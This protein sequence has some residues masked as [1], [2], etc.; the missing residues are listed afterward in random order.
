MVFSGGDRWNCI[1]VVIRR[2]SFRIELILFHPF[3]QNA[4]NGCFF[5]LSDIISF[6]HHK[7][8]GSLSCIVSDTLNRGIRLLSGLRISLKGNLIINSLCE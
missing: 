4:K 3:L 8:Y 1:S 5:I 6:F 7:L 2:S